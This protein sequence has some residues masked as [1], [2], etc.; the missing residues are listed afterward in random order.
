MGHA[1]PAAPTPSTETP[2]SRPASPEAPDRAAQRNVLSYGQEQ[3][4]FLDQLAPGEPTYNIPVV[5]RLRGELDV[6]ALQ[7]ALTVVVARHA[8][9]RTTF[10]AVDGEPFQT[11]SPAV[12]VPLPVDDQSCLPAGDRAAAAE[13][14]ARRE[15]TQPFDLSAGPLFRFRLLRLAGDDHL[16]CGTLHHIVADGW[17]MGLI[18]RELAAAYGA[19]RSGREPQL[20]DL[21]RQYFDFAAEQR[22]RLSSGALDAEL[23]YWEE[24]LRD[25]GELSLP[26][27]RP[28][29]AVF[30]YRGQSVDTDFPAEL[31]AGLRELAQRHSVSLF[32]VLT[33]ALAVV[34]AR[35]SEQDEIPL[36]TTM[37][38]RMEP[39]LENLVGFFVNMV[40]LRTD[41]SGNPRFTELLGR[42]RDLTLAAYDHQEVPFEKVVARLEP[43]RDASRNPLFQVSLQLLG[44]RTAG[45][46]LDLPGIDVE[47]LVPTVTRSRFDLALTFVETADRLTLRIEY[48]T[49][50][51]DAWRVEQLARHLERTLRAA[52]ADP[53]VRLSEVPLLSETERHELLQAGRGAE[54]PVRM[55]PVHVLIGERARSAPDAV[56]AVFE[57]QQLSY[58]ELDRRSTLLARHLRALGVRH[59][60]VV[61]VALPRGLQAWTALLGV[62]K[63]GAAFVV[64]DTAHPAERLAFV[65]A[66]AGVAVVVTDRRSLDVLPAPAGWTAVCLDRDRERIEAAGS[67]EPLAEWATPDSLA[68][69]LYTSGSTGQPKG[70]LVEHRAVLPFL[71]SFIRLLELGPGDRMLQFSSLAFDMSEAEIFSAW[72]SGATLVSGTQETLSSPEALARLMRDERVTYI[73]APPAV[74]TLVDPEP[75]DHLRTILVG[76]EACPPE[77]VNRWN[78]PGRRFFNGYGPT[79]AAICCTLYPCEQ[80]QW[81]TTPPIGGP[82]SHRRLYV[83]DRWGGLASVGVPGELLIGGDEGLARGYLNRPELTAERFVADPF[84]SEGRVYRSGDLVRWT[85]DG[86]LEFA[87]RIDTQVKLNGLRIELEEIEAVG[88]SHPQVAQLAVAAREDVR[89]ER[90]LVGYVV[91]VDQPPAVGDLRS[92]LGRHLPPYMLPTHW[93]FLDALPLSPNGKVHRAG[94]PAPGAR[95]SVV[96]REFTPP[97]TPEEQEVADVF[98]E[99]LCQSLVGRD[100]DFF[101]LGGDS[102]RAMRVASRVSKVFGV[103]L[104]VRTLYTNSTVRG[105]AEHVKAAVGH[106]ELP[107]EAGSIS[108][109]RLE[110][111]SRI[112]AFPEEQATRLLSARHELAELC[113]PLRLAPIRQWASR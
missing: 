16:L 54:E 95:A 12:N 78:L 64:L 84:R 50:L 38:G 112:E 66:D 56:A 52:V 71:T 90:R 18:D 105:L 42:V 83:V 73:G 7:A 53:S 6:A 98:A 92:H 91:P 82:L 36:G 67:G 76:G 96:F 79:E 62:L 103:S 13:R 25:L 74:L 63:A 89:G 60:D 72:L 31:Q 9:L 106:R 97:G 48:A 77:L 24:L 21:S 69:L 14:I 99:V 34:L 87:G 107:P 51:F 33:A 86:Q 19:L 20:A 40:V 27:D 110:V 111:L 57:G 17:S 68:Y 55:D 81:T 59:G 102:L 5:R 61:A 2:V 4:L 44:D 85:P 1:E 32:M 88:S 39:E 3:L 22:E 75:Y 29:P 15:A 8:V 30:G 43:A 10:R 94:L 109:L 35:H 11:V 113:R 65:L 104:P 58:G 93:V 46:G 80:V 70:A 23:G 28:R 45:T 108:P 47:S 37:L 26:T 41:V 100:D 101:L 49:D